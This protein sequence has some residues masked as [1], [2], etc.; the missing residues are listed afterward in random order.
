MLETYFLQLFSIISAHVTCVSLKRQR[1]YF[2]RNFV[3][4]NCNNFMSFFFGLKVPQ[5][6]LRIRK[7]SWNKSLEEKSLSCTFIFFLSRS[8]TRIFDL[9]NIWLSIVWFVCEFIWTNLFR[10]FFDFVQIARYER[11][12]KERE[13]WN[14]VWYLTCKR[15][16]SSDIISNHLTDRY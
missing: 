5:T 16:K 2:Q 10:L 1:I 8:N 6:R 3:E 4:V 9:E 7:W 11:Y 14:K 12:H 13:I 15:A